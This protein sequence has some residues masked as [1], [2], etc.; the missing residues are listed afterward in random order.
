MI[1]WWYILALAAVA[2]ATILTGVVCMCLEQIASLIEHVAVSMDEYNALQLENNNLI[3]DEL[4]I[5]RGQ[6]EPRE[7]KQKRREAK[8]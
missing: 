8:Q 5:T 1:N 4:G 2:V 6:M 3:R 7:I